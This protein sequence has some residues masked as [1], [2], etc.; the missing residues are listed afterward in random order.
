[1]KAPELRETRAVRRRRRVLGRPPGA[2]GTAARRD[3]PRALL[4]A[5]N[6]LS[7]RQVVILGFL[8][9]PTPLD[10]KPDQL[11]RVFGRNHS[12]LSPLSPALSLVLIL[13]AK[14]R[15]SHHRKATET[16]QNMTELW[17]KERGQRLTLRVLQKRGREEERA[18]E[19]GRG[20]KARQPC[21]LWGL[22]PALEPTASS[23]FTGPRRNHCLA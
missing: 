3:S 6:Q 16:S 7:T 12:E 22:L 13:G 4:A 23:L 21:V 10:A 9:K 19:E 1:M 8:M 5:G 17:R 15:Y 18:R 14:S 2:W 20:G 11:C